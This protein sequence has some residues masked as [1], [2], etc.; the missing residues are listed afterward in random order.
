MSIVDLEAARAWLAAHPQEP[1]TDAVLDA[2]VAVVL[3]V[4][5]E[6]EPAHLVARNDEMR[7]GEAAAS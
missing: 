5:R 2:A 4:L 6:P 7:A 3:P 1:P